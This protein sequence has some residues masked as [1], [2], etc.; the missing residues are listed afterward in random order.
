M[1]RKHLSLDYVGRIEIEDT[2]LDIVEKVAQFS[3]PRCKTAETLL[4]QCSVEIQNLRVEL[5]KEMREQTWMTAEIARL[6]V[7][8]SDC[9]RKKLDDALYEGEG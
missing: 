5:A 6:H 7:L 4:A 9:R 2:D 3:S 8:L 1:P